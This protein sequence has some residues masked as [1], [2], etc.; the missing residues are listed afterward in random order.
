MN[1]L[2]DDDIIRFFQLA[3]SRL[4][5]FTSRLARDPAGYDKVARQVVYTIASRRTSS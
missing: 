2:L 5:D 1:R 3:V 4:K